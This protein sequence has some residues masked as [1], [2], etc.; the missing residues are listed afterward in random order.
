MKIFFT[1]ILIHTL[2]FTFGQDTTFFDGKRNKVLDKQNAEYYE[3]VLHDNID[4]NRAKVIT[5]F[6]SGKIESESNFSDLKNKKLDGKYRE[7]FNNGQI[8]KDIDYKNNLYNGQFL[9]YW[10]NGKPKRVD[11]YENDKLISG[12]CL[13][14]IG[15]EIEYY[16]YEIMPEFPGGELALRKYLMI[17]V[18]Y[19]EIARENGIQGKVYVKFIVNTDGSISNVLIDRGVDS[20]LD[21]EALRVVRNMP[22]WIPGQQDGIKVRVS[23]IVPIN[24]ILQ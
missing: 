14:S 8:R 5:Y 6:I 21:K 17:S 24:F 12:K 10:P 7:Y 9:T 1:F 3:V 18:K 2:S 23:Y 16:A 15:N 4:T 13:D 11:I 19:P 22:K 20:S